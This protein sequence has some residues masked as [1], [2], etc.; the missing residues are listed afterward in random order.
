M[1]PHYRRISES[2]VAEPKNPVGVVEFYGGEGFGIYPQKTYAHFLQQLFAA[3]YT[4]IAVPFQMGLN[5][6]RIAQHLLLERNCIRGY[7]GYTED[8]P[9]HFWVGHSIGCKI[10]ALLEGGTE[11][12]PKGLWKPPQSY[13]AKLPPMEIRGIYDEP[14]LLLAPANPGTAQSVRLPIVP[15]LLDDLG[16]GVQPPRKE[17]VHLVEDN[18]LFGLT[19]VISF[20]NDMAAGNMSLPCSTVEWLVRTLKQ[21][22]PDSF[23]H[24]E[25]P[26]GHLEPNAVQV[27]PGTL[28]VPKI[29]GPLIVPTFRSTSRPLEPTALAFLQKLGERRNGATT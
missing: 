12:R 11:S 25:L 8:D 19:A 14:S 3:N 24:Q 15:D 1:K 28:L 26:G 27:A 21:K 22:H 18:D 29:T 5:H 20:K 9:P 13:T 6:A 17:L 7:L 2:W 23:F 10:I 4:I 16:L